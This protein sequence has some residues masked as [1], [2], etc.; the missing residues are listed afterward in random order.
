MGVSTG[1]L[2]HGLGMKYYE[3]LGTYWVSWGTQEVILDSRL[4][5]VTGLK[6]GMEEREKAGLEVSRNLEVPFWN[7]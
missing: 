4:I 1:G 5:N 6:V 3:I 2:F 7:E